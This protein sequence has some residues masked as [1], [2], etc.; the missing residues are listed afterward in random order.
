M[1]ILYFGLE[2]SKKWLDMRAD[3]QIVH[4]PLIKIESLP[5]DPKAIMAM[6]HAPEAFTHLLLTSKV[7]V[8]LLFESLNFANLLPPAMHNKTVVAVGQATAMEIE[9]HGFKVDLIALEECSEG[10]VDLL[11]QLDLS[12]AHIFWPCSA[13]SRDVIPAH[14]RQKGIKLT[15][16]PLYTTVVNQSIKP[17]LLQEIDQAR[18]LIFTSPSTVRAF[19]DLY[20]CIPEDKLITSIGPITAAALRL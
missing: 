20:G 6:M 13:L 10:I 5:L 18:E 14:C 17:L 1:K 7:A 3:G 4:C 2:L 19:R 16:L 11:S 12:D 9:K 15:A 8:R